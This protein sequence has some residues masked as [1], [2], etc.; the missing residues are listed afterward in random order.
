MIVSGTK[1]EEELKRAGR[2]K[3]KALARAIREGISSGQMP[4]GHKLPPV[5]DLAHKTGMTPGTVARAYTLLTDEGRLT[6]EVGRG[7][8]VARTHLPPR[9]D[10][11]PLIN[12]PIDTNADFRSSR[13]PDVGQG[14]LIDQAFVRLGQSHRRRHINYPTQETDLEAR[15]ATAA[16]LD[17]DRLGGVTADDVILGNGAQNC[18]LLALQAVLR[19]NN[20]V[21]L[22]EE[23]SYPG[24]RHAARLL[25]A[26]VVGLPI[27]DEGIIP[28]VFEQ[29]YRANGGQVLLTAAEVHS[30]TT[31]QTSLARKQVLAS[32]ARRLSITIIEDDCHTTA[33]TDIPCYR[34][35]LPEQAYFVSSVTKSVSGALRFGYV[36]APSRQ[37]KVLR[38]VAQSSFYGVAQPILDVCADLLTSGAAV[39]VRDKVVV[40]TRR[41]V[42]LAVN[43]LGAWDVRWREDAPFVF[44]QMPLGW[45]ASSFAM[46]CEKKGI[47]VKPADEFA[48][49]DGLAPNAVRLG[50]NTCVNED[51]FLGAMDSMNEML[52]N[53]HS[54]V[55]N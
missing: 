24:V 8:F 34:T 36:V 16:W 1:W 32:I 40:E 12:H 19:G 41:R 23:L 6:A 21:I 37:A 44:L 14:V 26:Q 4:A 3:Y 54:L 43:K 9:A 51:L 39:E 22:T 50:V 42:R 46:A 17:Q 28:E 52:G 15:T 2:S 30:P 13:V 29:A 33:P 18:C 45:R 7:T 31:I 25:R 5:R 49:P 11:E 35:M 48:L 10:V 27:D 20:P 55:D 47:L 38:Q 53:P